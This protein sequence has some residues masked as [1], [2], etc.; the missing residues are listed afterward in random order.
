MDFWG[1]MGGIVVND[2]VKLA[3][4]IIRE[5]RVDTFQKG[6]EFLVTVAL[7]TSAQDASGGRVVSGKQRKSAMTHII[8]G[9]TLG[10]TRTQGQNGLAALQGLSLALLI[11]TKHDGFI[12]RI[13]I[14]S[15]NIAH[16]LHKHRVGT[17]LEGVHP[18]GLSPKA[19]QIRKTECSEMPA[20]LAIRRLLQCVQPE[21]HPQRLSEDL[22]DL[23]VVDASRSAA[24]GCICQRIKPLLGITAAPLAT[25]GKE[26]LSRRAISVLLNPAEAPRMIL[27]R[28]ASRWL[29]L[30][31]F[32]IKVSFS[33]SAG[34]R[35]IVATGLPIGIALC[36]SHDAIVQRISLSRH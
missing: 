16:L 18:W 31:R 29:D 8:V 35:T 12:G 10:Q 14:E 6:Q 27:A 23:L 4:P 30:L 20:S 9:L 17:Q 24:A 34:L 26:T 13:Q 19:R 2:E 1:F 28:S 7:V 3:L 11:D 22:L 25:V 5:R 21:A 33:L 32:A 15:H 36:K